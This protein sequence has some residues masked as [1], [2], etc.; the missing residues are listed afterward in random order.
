M[1]AIFLSAS[2]VSDGNYKTLSGN[3]S[4]LVYGCAII[5]GI[6]VYLAFI[7]KDNDSS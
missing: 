3:T 5:K 4:N 1:V 6:F 2:V 7:P